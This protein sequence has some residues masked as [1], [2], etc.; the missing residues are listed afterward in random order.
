VDS[1]AEYTALSSTRSNTINLTM[2]FSLQQS[3]PLQTLLLC[4]LFPCVPR[5]CWCCYWTK[6]CSSYRCVIVTED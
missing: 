4:S 6:T 3:Y 2:T 1:K 5:W